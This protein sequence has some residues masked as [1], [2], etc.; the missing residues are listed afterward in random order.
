MSVRKVVRL[1]NELLMNGPWVATDAYSY[2]SLSAYSVPTQMLHG[3]NTKH[4]I[5]WRLPIKLK[6]E[7]REKKGPQR[8]KID[9]LDEVG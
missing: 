9:L 7:A 1:K 4:G 8:Y 6:D 2:N 3:V 5:T